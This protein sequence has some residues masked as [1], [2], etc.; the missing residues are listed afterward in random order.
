MGP[1]C[2]QN[3]IWRPLGR[4]LGRPGAPRGLTLNP[5]VAFWAILGRP[6]GGPGALWGALGAPLGALG[7]LIG[8]PG[9]VF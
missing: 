4:L 9:G 2:S 8:A 5:S 6:G 3:G 7:V 1:E